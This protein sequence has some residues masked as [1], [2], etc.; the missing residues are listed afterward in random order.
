MFNAELE[1]SIIRRKINRTAIAF[2][3][4]GAKVICKF[5]LGGGNHFAGKESGN[6][7]GL[8]SRVAR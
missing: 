2:S 7:T 1:A 4:A 6:R 3:K 8:R 5:I